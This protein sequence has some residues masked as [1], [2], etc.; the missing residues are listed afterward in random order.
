MSTEF[1]NKYNELV[2]ESSKPLPPVN[3]SDQAED[4]EK[5]LIDLIDKQRLMS[6]E[7]PKQVNEEFQD[8]KNSIL[9]QC[10]NGFD[11]DFDDSTVESDCEGNCELEIF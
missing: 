9:L 8:L 6:I 2:S 10:A 11:G 7:K 1:V 3:Q 5:K 4:L